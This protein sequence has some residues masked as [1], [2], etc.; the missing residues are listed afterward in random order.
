M[1][2]LAPQQR[3]C[4]LGSFYPAGVLV[5]PPLR[6]ATRTKQEKS[7]KQLGALG[8]VEIFIVPLQ[9]IILRSC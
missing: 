6:K 4:K 1:A 9:K 8:I 5:K 7:E 3:Q 2:A